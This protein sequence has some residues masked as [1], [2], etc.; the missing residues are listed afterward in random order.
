M[1]TPRPHDGLLRDE[2]KA[3]PQRGQPR[4]G[5][6]LAPVRGLPCLRHWPGEYWPLIGHVNMLTDLNIILTSDWSGQIT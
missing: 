1:T 3:G 2:D 4:G 6:Q 5:D